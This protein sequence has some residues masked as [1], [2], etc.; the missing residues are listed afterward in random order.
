MKR[1][2]LTHAVCLALVAACG[3]D[4]K[5]EHD[6]PAPSEAKADKGSAR[7]KAIESA[8][9]LRGKVNLDVKVPEVEESLAARCAV[10]GPPLSGTCRDEIRSIAATAE[11]F[12]LVDEANN[13][14]RYR[15]ASADAKSCELALDESFGSGGM[16]AP[17]PDR[18]VM[19]SADGPVH[20]R[21]GG[22]DFSVTIGSDGSV[23]V[24]DFLLGVYRVDG[25]ALEPVCTDTPGINWF[26]QSGK[27]MTIIR[28][29]AVYQLTRS[30]KGCAVKE[31]ELD[32]PIRVRGPASHA[33]GALYVAGSHSEHSANVV[34]RIVDGAATAVYGAEDAFAAGGLCSVNAV[35]QCGDQVCVADGNCQQIDR[36]AADGAPANATKLRD[37]VGDGV[38]GVTGLVAAGGAGLWISVMLKTGPASSP[39][40]SCDGAVFRLQ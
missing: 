32:A 8:G 36:F 25:N 3:S 29:A 13:L 37:L 12:Y 27:T 6:E 17:P 16:I 31:V 30:R 35:T 4:K 11:H 21:S 33:G 34:A 7:N 23:Y 2:L 22:P 10:P 14:R 9:D 20:M 24:Y 39:A 26:G 38:Y 15:I 5:D 19:Q 18:E 40:S 1:T 28:G